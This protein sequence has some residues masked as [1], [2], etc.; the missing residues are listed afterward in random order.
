MTVSSNRRPIGLF[1]SGFGGLTVLRELQRALPGESYVYLGDNAR[2]PYGTK[3]NETITRYSRECADFLI[4]QGVDLVIVACNTASAAALTFLEK[5]LPVPVIGTIDPA[6]RAALSASRT[7]IIGVLGTNATVTS[8][9]YER[10]IAAAAPTV[11]VVSQPCP[12]FVPLVEAGMIAGEIV[13]KTVELYLSPIVAARCDTVILACTHYPLLVAALQKFLGP[14]VRIV[15]CSRAIADDVT[16]LRGASTP[17]VPLAGTSYFVTDEVG[18][19]NF[20]AT[21]FLGG[22]GVEAVRIEHLTE[23][24]ASARQSYAA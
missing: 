3:G 12:L 21:E 7:G 9:V 1:D 5:E 20:L 23:K 14:E 15:E 13:D 18:R 24:S 8:Q 6:V 4:G 16:K 10:A 22:A 19:F 17:L 2:C 11:K